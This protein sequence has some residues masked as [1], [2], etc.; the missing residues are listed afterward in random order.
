M[1][2][3]TN[4]NTF[5]VIIANE[6]YLENNISQVC[7][8][9]KDGD[10]FKQYCIK[11][12][13]IPAENI[14][15]RNNATRNQMRSEM[16]WLN[17]IANAF[18]EKSNIIVYY[19]G[20]GMPDEENQKAYLLPSDGIANDPESAYS[21]ES[22]YNQLGALNV[23]SIVV[24]L[25]ACFSGFQRDG[26]MLTAT[27][28]VAIKPKEEKLNGNVIVISASKGDETA[29][30]YQ[31]KGHGLFTYYLLKKLQSSKGNITLKKLGNYIIDNVK[32]TSMRKNSK[33]QTPT[34]Y[35]SEHKSEYLF[36]LKLRNNK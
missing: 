23:N 11:T 14:H 33:I 21:L 7:Y 17:N 6:K 10:V 2:R 34:I 13:G 31:E 19:S 4:N 28:G 32:Q 29:Y 3:N 36:N 16:K 24:F 9:Q 22:F 15:V 18:G 27:K 8:A 35:A 25:D 20:H 26:G 12:L 30:P 1:G 5:V